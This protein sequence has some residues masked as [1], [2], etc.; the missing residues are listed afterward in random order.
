M[1]ETREGKLEASSLGS[2]A[3]VLL[4][5]AHTPLSPTARLFQPGAAS[6]LT[7]VDDASQDHPARD[8]PRMSHPPQDMY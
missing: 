4:Y 7:L 8:V 2:P 5:A 6:S 3:P 1:Q